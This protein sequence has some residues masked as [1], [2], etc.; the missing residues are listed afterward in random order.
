MPRL[1]LIFLLLSGCSARPNIV[2]YDMTGIYPVEAGSLNGSGTVI[3]M[4]WRIW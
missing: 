4:N 1:L 2:Q 3:N